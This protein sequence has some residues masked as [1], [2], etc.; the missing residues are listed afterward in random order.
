M[1][2]PPRS[3]EAEKLLSAANGRDE[4]SKGCRKSSS[5]FL[6]VN[7]W[8]SWPLNREGALKQRPVFSLRCGE[9]KAP[10]ALRG[11]VA[12]VPAGPLLNSEGYLAG[13]LGSPMVLIRL[14]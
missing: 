1:S 8:E 4:V 9:A 14:F 12:A 6:C 7:C 2:L 3:A 5:W 13:R 11:R 10:D